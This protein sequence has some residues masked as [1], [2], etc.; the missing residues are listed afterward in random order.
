M[1]LL[2]LHVQDFRNLGQ[3]SLSPSPHATIAVGQNGQGKTNLLEALYFLATLKPLRAGR[4]SELVRWGAPAARVTG[5]FLLKGAEREISVEVS[6]GVRQSFVDG[7]KAPSLEEYFGGVSVVAFTP[8]DLEVVKGGPDSR[9]GFLDRAVFNRFP[10]FLRESREYARALKNRNRLLR[11][12]P[13]DSVYLEAYDET[14]AKAGA[15]VYAR[16]RAL[17][18]ELAPRAQA[19]FAS[20]GRTPDPASYGYRPAHLGDLD[21]AQADEAALAHALREALASRS[22]RDL[23]RGFTS[24]GPHADDVSVTL[25]SRSARAYASQGQQRALVLGWKIAEIENLE[26]STGFLPLL[27]L[28]DVSSELDPE[29]NAY[30]M[31]YLAES[32]AQVFLTTTDASLVRAAAAQDTLWM[33]VRSGEVSFS[34]PGDSPSG[35][36]SPPDGEP[37]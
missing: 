19:T 15:R 10:A 21:F 33:G 9:R 25:G 34:P 23:D 24:V 30:L 32:G 5:R 13:V 11:T 37:G 36:S 3:V 6:G 2:A 18:A 22:R 12:G 17:M 31:R 29:R 20:I 14:L 35:L 1:R 26:A 16:R 8:D 4:L 27:L 28:D 7:K